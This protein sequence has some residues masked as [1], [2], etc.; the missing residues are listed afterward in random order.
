M[1]VCHAN[2][3]VSGDAASAGDTH[4]VLEVD[5]IDVIALSR[6][7]EHGIIRSRDEAVFCY[8]IDIKSILVEEKSRML[9]DD[10]IGRQNELV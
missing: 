9:R 7:L 4:W 3:K 1:L 2:F 8:V 5:L 10:Y 6:W